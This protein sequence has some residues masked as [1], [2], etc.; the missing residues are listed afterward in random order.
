MHR[1]HAASRSTLQNFDSYHVHNPPGIGWIPEEHMTLSGKLV[2]VA[3]QAD[4]G[5]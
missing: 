1:Q 2:Q 3:R 5:Q 4:A